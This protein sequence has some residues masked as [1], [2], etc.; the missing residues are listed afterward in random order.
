MAKEQ[1]SETVK[2]TVRDYMEMFYNSYRLHSTL[3]YIGP[4]AFEAQAQGL[5]P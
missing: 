5:T 4:N 1:S 2:A 3:G